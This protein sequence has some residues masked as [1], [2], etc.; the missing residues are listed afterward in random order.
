MNTYTVFHGA[1][2]EIQKELE[3]IIGREQ[4]DPESKISF[5]RNHG[6]PGTDSWG[7]LYTELTRLH[8]IMG[9]PEF[10]GAVGTS[11][12]AG[13]RYP[14]SLSIH[15]ESNE[16]FS[17]ICGKTW[18]DRDLFMRI[19]GFDHERKPILEVVETRH[20]NFLHC[21]VSSD[22]SDEY[23]PFKLLRV[24]DGHT[25]LI[26]TPRRMELPKAQRKMTADSLNFGFENALRFRLLYNKGKLSFG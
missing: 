16:Y 14:E 3:A 18:G 9:S 21:L 23:K 6:A 24:G 13:I 8:G 11:S 5:E 2:E 7:E 20:K 26:D 10:I 12:A 25:W 22:D 4:M 19:T 1:D 15:T 17:F